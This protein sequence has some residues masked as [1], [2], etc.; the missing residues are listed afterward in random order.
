[1]LVIS[2]CIEIDVTAESMI[3]QFLMPE[4]IMV[5]QVHLRDELMQC[6]RSMAMLI[7]FA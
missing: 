1:V 4:K 7:L 6:H 2:A 5:P 3:Y